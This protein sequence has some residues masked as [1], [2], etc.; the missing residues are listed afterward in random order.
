MRRNKIFAKAVALSMAI[1]MVVSMAACGS[2]EEQET[3]KSVVE[4]TTT[5]KDK[6]NEKKETTS[7]EKTSKEETSDVEETST[8]NEE[9]SQ[10]NP[11]S[12]TT[13]SATDVSNTGDSTDSEANGNT[14]NNNAGSTNTGNN[15]NA[16]S[17]GSA[18]NGNAGNANT[19]SSGNTG[20]GN[21]GNSNTNGGSTSTPVK[22]GTAIKNRVSV[23]DPSIVVGT[24]KSGKKCY[25]IFG[26]H[27]AW[28]KSYDLQ[29]WTTF[30][31]NINTSYN[32]LFASAFDWANNGDPVYNNGGNMWAPDV[33]WNPNMN[34]WCM[35]M[36]INGCSWNS[37]IVL[38][39]ADNLEGDW[40]YVG[41][42]IYS[43]FTSSGTY[44]YTQTD[45]V[46]VTGD[47][48]FTKYGGRYY[49]NPYQFS[50]G[51]TKC[52]ASTW[53]CSTG[54]HAIDPCVVFDKNGDLYMSYGSWSG[55]IWMI[56]LDKNTG[57][58]DYTR[59]YG[60]S[61]L[62]NAT[63]DPYMGKKISGAT[64]ATGEASYI[65]YDSSTD[66]YYL[67]VTYGGLVA[68][69]GYHIRLFRSKDIE[70]TYVD[71]DGTRANARGSNRDGIGIKLFGNYNLSSLATNNA[72]AQKG[73]K[74]GGHNSAF[75]DDNGSHYLIYHTRFNLGNE[76]H[77]VRVH[78]QFVNEDG[79][80]VTAV[81]E[82]LGSEISTT[83][84][85]MDDMTGTYELVNM[86]TSSAI[87]NVGML[88]NGSIT[89]NADGTLSGTYTG[90]WSYRNQ[91]VTLNINGTAYKGVFFKQF[92]E[93][94][95]HKEV[96]TFTV[97]GADTS[98]WGTK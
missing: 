80:L 84:Y 73:Y 51:N 47:T 60:V 23:H 25:Y 88:S 95:S 69:G 31:N 81:Y 12:Q 32:S 8:G 52:E 39:T 68:N 24:D 22:T 7:E 86:G 21:T 94:S 34:K 29:N 33:I 42:V 83:G 93:S 97:I 50:D 18:G 40:T 27:M 85:S 14:G 90:T 35:Y 43:G 67:Y 49:G 92:D 44:S 91:Y 64:G 71:Y 13:E 75:I 66:Y 30:T 82:Y 89:F 79:W 16:G 45:Y 4:K 9:T 41:P 70:G 61:D 57:L 36:S 28:A 56:K 55:G 38:L 58:R 87:S 78:Q 15:G 17:N 5:K 2:D 76:W 26:S 63:E 62:T 1:A 19:G 10:E 48:D 65:V 77:Q 54:A 20:T 37:S 74:S 59:T 72:N 3:T 53:N 46:K 11:E 96:M 6:D 98:I